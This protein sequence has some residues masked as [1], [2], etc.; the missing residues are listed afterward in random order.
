VNKLQAL[1]GGQGKDASDKEADEQ[2]PLIRRAEVVALAL[3]GLLIIA[4]AA[5]LYVGK[6]FFLPVATAFVIGTMF[7]P[8]ASFLAKRGVPRALAA[9]LIVFVSFGSLTAVIGLI[10]APLVAWI[11]RLPELAVSL[12]AKLQPYEHLTGVWKQLHGVFGGKPTGQEGQVQL[13]NIDWMQSTLQ[14]LSPTFTEILL[15]LVTLVL[16][17]ASWPSLRRALV[18]TF[19]QH[20]GRLRALKIINEI[21]TSLGGYLLVVTMINIC[22]GIATG[23][24]CWAAS[25]PNP[26]GLGALAATLNFFPIIG[27]IAMFAV[28][29]AVGA[30]SFETLS[31]GML[32]PAGFVAMTFIEGHFITPMIIGRRLELN[33]LAVFV[34]LAFWTWLWGPMGGF[35]AGPLLIVALV[36]REHLLPTDEPRLPT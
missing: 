30:V 21:E 16:F 17:I 34:A 9:V 26:V 7:A 15:F 6:A 13:P 5:V 20:D 10:A 22:V 24:I 28:L 14:F 23:L 3:V 1:A 32:G 4:V 2:P 25:M 11:N 33:A 36:L 18:M 27:P 29:V 35:L 19:S 31:A 8:A 12:K